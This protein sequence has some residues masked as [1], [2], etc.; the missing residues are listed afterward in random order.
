[1]DN[2]TIEHAE[3][4]TTDPHYPAY[5]LL[6]GKV[7]ERTGVD[8]K[9]YAIGFELRLPTAWNGRFLYQGNGG[10]AG[11]VVPAEG[12]GVTP[13]A[14]GGIGALQRGF[15]VLSTDDGHNANDPTNQDASLV[16]N[17]LFGL[18]PQARLDYGYT[19]VGTMTPL[20]KAIITQYYG[21]APSYS[22]I[23]GCSN[24][25]RN[26]MVAAAR[27]AEQF[28]G[29]LAGSPAHNFTKALL[30]NAW[31]VQSFQL[32]DPDIRKSFS[33]EDLNLVANGVLTACDALDG[34]EDGLVND[35]QGCQDTFN[36]ADLQCEDVKK[37]TCL[38]EAQVV[39]LERSMAGP[40][41]AAGEQLYANW[42][43]DSGMGAANWRMWK[44]ESPMATREFYPLGVTL[45]GAILPYVAITPPTTTGGTPTALIDFLANFDFETD[46]PKI[47]AT[48]ATFPESGMDLLTIPDVDDPQIAEFKA[49]GGKMIIF[50]GASDGIFSVNDIIEWYEKL[51]V[52]HDSNAED[53]VRL[54]VVPGM[55]H[56]GRGPATDQFDALTALMN[57]VE[58]DQAPEQ[59]IATVNPLNPELPA[60]WSK[61]RTRPICV[62]PGIAQ[63]QGGDL[64]NAESFECIVP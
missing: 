61:T 33:R 54:F 8:G 36:L 43:Y 59:L 62:W 28:D 64:E 49:A 48:D 9:T 32:V 55:N 56:C 53:F 60:D 19:A 15:A 17:V 11:V 42:A 38:S 7:N 1:L 44:V 16:S 51:D 27:Y 41:K 63:F 4:I 50:Q 34:A 37:A 23:Y 57:W 24:G 39:A 2:L 3:V 12:I 46:T 45:S 25:G 6:Q 31:D 14:I 40:T 30:Q 26:G 35:L 10:A 22:Y 5:C 29:I 20:A 58:G 52:N 18:D 13:Y 47:F 21:T